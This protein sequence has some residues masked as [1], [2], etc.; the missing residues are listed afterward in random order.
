VRLT[1]RDEKLSKYRRIE[2]NAYRRRVTIVSGEWRARDVFD[3]QPAELD[4]RV[5]LSDSDSSEPV[6]PDSPEGQ[7]ILLDAVRSLERRLSPEARATICAN[8]NGLT[9]NDPNRNDFYLKLRSIYDFI[10]KALRFTRK[11]KSNAAKQSVK[12]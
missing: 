3:A 11:E 7:T 6:A 9:S 10:P 2:V 4:D 1:G 12:D 8:R 5:S